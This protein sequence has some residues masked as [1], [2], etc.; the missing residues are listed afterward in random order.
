[1][2]IAMHAARLNKEA[3]V[4]RYSL[5][6]SGRKVAPGDIKRFCD[7]Y[8]KVDAETGI[9]MC[10]SMGLLNR[11]ELLF[12]SDEWHVFKHRALDG[13]KYIYRYGY[14]SR[15]AGFFGQFESLAHRLAHGSQP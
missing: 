10:A 8:R 13:V 3:G 11:D 5:V 7:L 14:S 9:Y 12:L 1:M 15:F 6:T 2:Y 4:R